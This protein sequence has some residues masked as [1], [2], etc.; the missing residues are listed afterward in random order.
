MTITIKQVLGVDVAQNELVVT[1]GRMHNDWSP[2]LYAHQVFA[3]TQ[4]RIFKS[5]GVG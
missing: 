5:D 2:E 4:K 1:I 3:N